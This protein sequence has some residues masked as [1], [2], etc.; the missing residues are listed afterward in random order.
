MS[1]SDRFLNLAKQL[2]PMPFTIAVLL[3]FLA[4]VL[5]LFFT[6]RG[7][8]SL[9]A[10]SI[11]ILEFWE[12]GLWT[13]TLMIF[14]MQ[15]MLMLVLGHVLARTW[16][17]EQLIKRTVSYCSTTAKAAAIV[18]FLTVSIALFNWALG[19]IF[20]AIFAR[21]IAE[22]AAQNKLEI[23]YPL[24]GAC[25]YSGLM[26]WHGGLSGSA[27]IRVND[28]NH[29][30]MEKIG[31]IAP[32]ETIFSEMNIV[33][34]IVLLL[35]LPAAMWWIGKRVRNSQV[36]IVESQILEPEEK[37]E[38]A[39]K[40]D[41]SRILAYSFAAIILAIAFYKALVKPENI[42]LDFLTPN[43]INL[44]LLGL[45]IA[46]HGSFSRFI[47]A[48][49][50]AITGA[51]GILIQF[52]LYFGIMG[53]MTQSGL[54]VIFSDFFV[55]ISNEF[56]YPIFTFIS[57]ALVNI[58]V[59]SGGGQWAVQGAIIIDAALELGV[60]IPKSIMA[61][62]Y[63]DQLTN[64]LQPFWAL[65]LLGITG[66]KAREILPYTMVLMLLGIVIFIV[67]LSIF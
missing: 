64:M 62:A 6:D 38:G 30:F 5:A 40:M 2:L 34:S 49:E 66:L 44:M 41:S 56:T 65:P 47:K 28:P 13:G 18:T 11:N 22:H 24:I 9:A 26:V 51:T 12:D 53:I 58:F 32:S 17:A 63:G 46:L 20:G 55:S 4:M 23:N 52:P 31:Q 35:V 60:S 36:S 16:L 48:I 37:P 45:G 39:E 14:A 33:I 25:G 67:G 27:P 54:V 50:E 29:V 3:T 7:D 43:F 19:L 10:Y 59:P 21:K 8:I 42:S 61:M 15:M 57:A 1:F